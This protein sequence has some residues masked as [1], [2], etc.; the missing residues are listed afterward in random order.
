MPQVPGH[1]GRHEQDSNIGQEFRPSPAYSF[2]VS[3][4][5]TKLTVHSVCHIPAYAALDARK[6]LGTKSATKLGHLPYS[7]DLVPCLAIPTPDDRSAGVL[8]LLA[9]RGQ[10]E[11]SITFEKKKHRA[12]RK[13][14]TPKMAGPVQCVNKHRL[15][16]GNPGTY[17]PQI[18]EQLI[19]MNLASTRN[20]RPANCVCDNHNSLICDKSVT[21]QNLAFLSY[22]YRKKRLQKHF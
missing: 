9:L 3:P 7:P 12:T 21:T 17:L 5:S 13:E 6:F 15:Y 2:I 19:T 11:L 8:T 22:W 14:P 16:G 20:V 18:V 4:S 1:L 10:Q